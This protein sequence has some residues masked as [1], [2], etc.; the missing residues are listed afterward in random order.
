MSMELA[1]LLFEEII[2]ALKDEPKFRA[3]QV[4][5][6]IYK[7][8]ILDPA[9]MSNIGPNA[10]ELLKDWSTLTQVRVQESDDGETWKFLWRL[11]DRTLVESVL[12]CAD[13]RR[14][15]CVS[16]Q[17]GCP[18]K[19]AFCASGKMGF[20]RN[21]STAEIVEQVVRIHAYLMEKGEAV[22][23]IVFMGMGEPLE[24]LEPVVKALH[25]LTHPKLFGLSQRHIT[26]STVGVIE[27]IYKLA[28]EGLKINLALSL[29]A[30]NQNIRKK[31]IPYARKYGFDELMKAVDD[32]R[33]M[34]GRD[35]TFEYTLIRGINDQKEHAEEL[36]KLLRSRPCTVNLISYNPVPGLKIEKPNR[37]EIIAFRAVLNAHDIVHTC[38]YTKGDDIAA[39]CGQL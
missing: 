20:K 19:C 26:L 21:L 9:R 3:A 36:A 39:A 31:I 13:T 7:K 15:V 4:V 28:D 25:I 29:H 34:T 5:D 10:Q 16:S 35:I 38:R 1:G 30:P 23:H 18:A 14:T 2:T 8:G 11:H 37:E 33:D 12:I 24:N 17:V 27:G 22:N 32:Y 6:W